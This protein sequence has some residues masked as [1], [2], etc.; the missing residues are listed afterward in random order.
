MRRYSSTTQFLYD[1]RTFAEVV[2][3]KQRD[4][5]DLAE[6]LSRKISAVQRFENWPY[7]CARAKNYRK[8]E[9]LLD[10]GSTAH[11]MRFFSK[12]SWRSF[13]YI[14]RGRLNFFYSNRDKLASTCTC[15]CIIPVSDEEY[16]AKVKQL[17]VMIR[18]MRG[19]HCT[20]LFVFMHL[21]RR[22]CLGNDLALTIFGY[23]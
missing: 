9:F 10:A 16:V 2:T 22:A 19:P 14:V 15:R 6:A 21:S 11:E 4:A 12:P 13:F 8:V 3:N 18:R 1:T 5:L 7:L 17:D 20:D 23:L